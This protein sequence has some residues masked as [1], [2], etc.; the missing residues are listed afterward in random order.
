MRMKSKLGVE[1]V[2]EVGVQLL[3]LLG[4]WSYKIKVISYPTLDS[5]KVTTCPDWWV[6]R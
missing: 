6:G 5:V 4:G 1:V 3:V 2:V